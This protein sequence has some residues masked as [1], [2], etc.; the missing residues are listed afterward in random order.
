MTKSSIIT[1]IPNCRVEFN[2]KI[3]ED[4]VDGKFYYPYR[5]KLLSVLPDR[6]EDHLDKNLLVWLNEYDKLYYKALVV[7]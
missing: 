2:R 1:I 4:T 3:M 5:G 6:P 7:R